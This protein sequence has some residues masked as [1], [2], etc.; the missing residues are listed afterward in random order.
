[1]EYQSKTEQYKKFLESSKTQKGNNF[2]DKTIKDQIKFLSEDI[3][4]KLNSFYNIDTYQNLFLEKNLL[5]IKN[6]KSLFSK[7]EGMD[8]LYKW[9]QEDLGKGGASSSLFQYMK[10]LED[11]ETKKNI[12]KESEKMNIKN[13]ILYG[14][15][16]VGKTHNYK[17]LISLIEQGQSQKDI[18][19]SIKKNELFSNENE[20]FK[21]V[22]EEKRVEFI[23]FH[24]SFGYEDFIEGFRPQENGNIEIEDGIFKV[25]SK[26]AKN[27]LFE[28]DTKTISFDDAYDNLR[29][30]YLENG[31]DKIYSVSNVEILIHE[32]KENTIKVQSLNAKDK[33]YVKK[34]DLETVVKAFIKNQIEKPADI[35]KLDVKKDTISLA[36]LYYP[37]GKLITKIMKE[38]QVFGKEE[39][40]FYLVIDELNRG[41]ISKI[42]GELIT[43]IE[44]SKRD[45]YEVTLPYSKQKFSVP[46]NLYIIG[47]MN[48]TDKSIALIDVALRRRFT[49]IKMQPNSNLVLPSFKTTFEKLNKKIKNDLGEEYQIGH[50]YFMNIDASEL[51]F[52][53][54]YKIKPLLEE[55]YYGDEELIEALKIINLE[56]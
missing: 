16:G 9:D 15:P 50:S 49:F 11:I 3:P 26:N 27:L 30:I 54:E 7:K 46:S 23:T 38:N 45:D 2:K 1:M 36:G 48:T 14:A 12:Y 22:E 37:I 35:K 34:S 4:K 21:Q 19:D 18:F 41:N 20:T 51:E 29:G 52:V 28:N 31:L 44:E 17:K 25:I 33:Q 24:Q 42:F 56:S 47:T 53:L 43:L 8:E 32:F 55:Y 5:V 6:L 39:K 40:N 13:I 10:F